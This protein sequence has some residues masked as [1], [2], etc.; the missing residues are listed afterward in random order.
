M[1]SINW[2]RMVNFIPLG[3]RNRWGQIFFAASLGVFSGYYLW[4]EPLDQYF[5]AQAEQRRRE[6]VEAKGRETP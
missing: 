3:A 5:A 6:E 1:E 2:P 4:K